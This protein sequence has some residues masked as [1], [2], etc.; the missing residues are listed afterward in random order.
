MLLEREEYIEQAYFFRALRERL[1]QGVSTQELLKTI[2]QEILSTTKLPL[3]ID[4]M[5]TELRFTGGFASAMARLSHY[6]TPF[7]AFVIHEAERE[8]GRLDFRVALEIL[9][10]EAEYKAKGA[11]VQGVFLYQFETLCRNRLGYDKGLEAMAGDPIYDE[12]WRE[13]ILDLRRQVGLIDIADMIFVRSEY[14]RQLRGDSGKP[15]LFGEKEGKIALAN[16]RKDPLYLFAALSRHLGYP[17]VPRPKREEMVLL[18]YYTL[19][20]RVERLEMRIKLLEEEQRGGIDLS[21]FYVKPEDQQ[22]DKSR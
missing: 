11:S 6:F 17:S 3:A 15:I 13:F 5:T 7:Q 19:L 21:Q 10:K 16:R 4:F 12:N 2:K 14:Y 18:N 20:R 9:E 22:K 8:D 1:D